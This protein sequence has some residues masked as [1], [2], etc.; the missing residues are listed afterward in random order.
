[1]TIPGSVVLFLVGVGAFQAARRLAT[2]CR[3]VCLLLSLMLVLYGVLTYLHKFERTS[4]SEAANW[5][6]D[7]LCMWFGGMIIGSF[8]TLLISGEFLKLRRRTPALS[9]PNQ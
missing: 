2:W 3:R 7:H 5:R 6:I 9:P 8:F 4:L 1:M